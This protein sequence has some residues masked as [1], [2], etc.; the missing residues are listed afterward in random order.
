MFE[1]ET[2]R[3]LDTDWYHVCFS[4]RFVNST[5]FLSDLVSSVVEKMADFSPQVAHVA[6]LVED[7]HTFKMLQVSLRRESDCPEVALKYRPV[8]F[9]S[10]LSGQLFISEVRS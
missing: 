6:R 9:R 10:S 3:H 2:W 4:A 8:S 7:R 1:M 5:F